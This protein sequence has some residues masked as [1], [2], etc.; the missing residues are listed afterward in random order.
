MRVKD[1]GS[2]THYH[3]CYQDH[4]WDVSKKDRRTIASEVLTVH[5]K[6][7]THLLESLRGQCSCWQSDLVVFQ[8]LDNLLDS[9]DVFGELGVVCLVP[10]DDLFCTGLAHHALN[11]SK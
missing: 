8:V 6:Q 7:D 5:A 11:V 10:F 4:L 9:F 3:G 2:G 1:I